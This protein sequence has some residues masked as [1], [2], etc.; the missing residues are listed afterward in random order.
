[1]SLRTG[2]AGSVGWK[3][4]SSF[5]V[6]IVVDEFLPLVSESMRMNI[7]RIE[8]EAIYAGR[9]I[10]DSEQWHAGRI[11]VSGDVRMELY[12]RGAETLF[13]HMFG[14][15]TSSTF[16]PSDLAAKSVTFQI[17][18]PGVDGTIRPFVYA[19][20][21]V[22]SWELACAEGANARLLLNLLGKAE[23][24]Y[25]T[26]SDGVTTDSD[27]TVT[28]STAQFSIADIG[29]P[30]SGTGI[31]ASTTIASIN[32]A[33]SVE[34]SAN[35]T[36]SGT[37]IAFTIGQALASVSYPA[38][39]VPFRY[40]GGTVTVGGSAVPVRQVTLAGDN[41][42]SERRFLGAHT[43]SAPYT[44]NLRSFTGELMAE[45]T[46]LDEY[47]LFVRGVENA[48]VLTF[49]AGSNTL[50]ITTNVRYDGTTPNIAGRGILE[51]P[52]PF[53]CIGDGSD[54]DAITAVIV[55]A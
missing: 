48:L 36:A 8:S 24:R 35:A 2:L 47:N 39:L 29:S 50:T 54:A 55:S 30:I 18:R 1:M 14:T 43:T 51:Q 32:S 27:A 6:P 52:M 31:P 16:T 23:Y 11:S 13:E 26:V 34:L 7:E 53:K 38:S 41:A 44:T 20:C 45:F 25:R 10:I 28:S 37:S 5:G 33:T 19:G 4:E 21:K 9:E 40:A 42:L 49:V 22:A 3:A 46:D 12:D 17:G 15:D